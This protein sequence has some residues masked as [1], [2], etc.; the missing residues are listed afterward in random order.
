MA[1]H[2]AK[3]LSMRRANHGVEVR[4]NERVNVLK[5]ANAQRVTNMEQRLKAQCA[6]TEQRQRNDEMV[7]SQRIKMLSFSHIGAANHARDLNALEVEVQRQNNGDRKRS[8]LRKFEAANAAH[9]QNTADAKARHVKEMDGLK[10]ASDA[11]TLRRD[12]EMVQLRDKNK[13]QSDDVKHMA[14]QVVSLE[15]ELAQSKAR[16]A[17]HRHTILENAQ[18]KERSQKR[19]LLLVARCEVVGRLKAAIEKSRAGSVNGEREMKRSKPNN[20]AEVARLIQCALTAK[21]EF[22]EEMRAHLDELVRITAM[23]SNSILFI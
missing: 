15:M 22:G 17:E 12:F 14:L 6:D 9:R 10:T 19:R 18:N 23:T 21:D 2:N 20:E 1:D 11:Q 16:C 7:H 3:M 8:Q 13:H 5:L 4:R